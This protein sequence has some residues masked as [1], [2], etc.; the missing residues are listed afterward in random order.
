[1]HVFIDTNILLNFFHYTSDELD[2]LNNVFA[3]HDQGAASVYLTDQVCDEFRRNRE[4]KI[5]DALKRFREVKVT[6]QLPSF[7]REYEE[8]SEIRKLSNTL[9]KKLI[10]ILAKANE[11]IKSKALQADNLINDIFERSEI[12]KTTDD[13]YLQSKKRMEIG[14]PPGKQGSLGD[15]I[16]WI[17][18]LSAVPTNEMLHIISEDGDFYSLLDDNLI[19]PF[20]EEEWKT[21]KNSNICVYRTLSQFMKEH[22]DGVTLSFDQEKRSLIDN[23][24]ESGS[25]A[26]TH[27]IIAKLNDYGYFSLEEA[28]LILD[29][30]VSNGQMG[31]IITDC[32]VSDFLTKVALPQ[33]ENLPSPDH[34]SIL[35]EVVTDQAE[36]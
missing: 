24:A 2:A 21:Q 26:Q 11:D 34:Q 33:R 28:R 15:A 36:R 18:L 14:N 1:M 13:I 31:M 10:S 30:A 27:D 35:E 17:T 9:R 3:S 23:L 4:A 29:A 25:F 8:Y 12:I 32:D 5:K 20:L 19:N 22:F 16:N 6:A 7:M